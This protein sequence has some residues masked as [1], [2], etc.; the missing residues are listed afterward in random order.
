MTFKGNVT[1]GS[2]GPDTNNFTPFCPGIPGG[3]LSPYKRAPQCISKFI[4]SAYRDHY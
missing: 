4:K 2:F 1:L 3:P